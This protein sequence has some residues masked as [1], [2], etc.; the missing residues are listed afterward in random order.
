MQRKCACI[1]VISNTLLGSQLRTCKVIYLS[2][3][4]FGSAFGQNLLR[5]L[6]EGMVILIL[7]WV[8]N[9]G[10]FSLEKKN[11]SVA[12]CSPNVYPATVPPNGQGTKQGEGKSNSTKDLS[13]KMA[14]EDQIINPKKLGSVPLLGGLER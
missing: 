4:P 6:L 7:V 11:I 9:E 13:R 12:L 8:W 2:W 1:I 14:K 3:K 5:A 10:Y